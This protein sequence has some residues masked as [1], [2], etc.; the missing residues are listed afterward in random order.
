MTSAAPSPQRLVLRNTLIS[1]AGQIVATPLSILVSAVTGRYLGAADFGQMYLAWQV[2]SFGFLLVEWGHG[3]VLQARV[4][5]DRSA[6]GELLGTTLAWRCGAALVVYGLLAVGSLALRYPGEFQTT[7][8]LVSVQLLLV[9]LA[10]ACQDTARGFE[11]TDVS[12][13]AQVAQ[14]IVNLLIVVPTL[15]LGGGL[16]AVL[17]AQAVASA[18]LLAFVWTARR[19]VGVGR[20]SASLA[21]LKIYARQGAPFLL[22]GF[23]MLL[24]PNVDAILLSK[25]APSEVVGWH[26]A[27]RKLINPLI[28]PVGMLTAALYP[29]LARLHTED[30][31]AF[32]DMVRGALRGAVI[33]AVPI[34]L[35]CAL[36]REVGILIFSRESYGPAQANLLALSPFLF[37]LFFSMPLGTSILSSGRERAWAG[38]QLLCVVV[39]S[40]L[41]P[42]L[43]PWFQ[44]RTGNGGLGVCV[45]SVVSEVLMVGGGVWLAVD[46]LFDRSFAK[47]VARTLA[48]GAAMT[49]VAL[50]L[51]RLSPWLAAPVALATY[52]GSLWAI[53]GLDQAQIEIVRGALARRLRRR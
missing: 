53:G 9:T 11:R 28:M 18:V 35:C 15:L 27:A 44:A 48:A 1:L 10:N 49:A 25:L 21:T 5:R 17:T 26:A 16:R 34:A 6:A 32:R 12:A 50:L 42:L 38:V 39:S 30:V 36:Y 3:S 4:A 43:I 46:G 51:A 47:S 19:S 7:L 29:T 13:Y 37:L 20:L 2:A 24:Q 45:A 14:P 8:T 52:F 23:A 31:R 41:D 33:L 22:F 40:V